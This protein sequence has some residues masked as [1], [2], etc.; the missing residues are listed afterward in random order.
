[1]HGLLIRTDT[2]EFFDH[3]LDDSRATRKDIAFLDA[4]GDDW[5][6]SMAIQKLPHDI[7]AL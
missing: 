3:A 7:E 4:S 2:R 6:T 1:M 5:E